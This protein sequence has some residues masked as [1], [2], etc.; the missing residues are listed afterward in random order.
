MQMCIGLRIRLVI[1]AMLLLTGVTVGA[2]RLIAAIV[3]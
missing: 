3:G 1:T 2:E